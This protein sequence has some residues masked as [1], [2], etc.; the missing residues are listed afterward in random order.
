MNRLFNMITGLGLG[1]GLMYLFD[2]DR[3]NRRRGLMRDQMIHL[4]RKTGDTL[5]AAFND[6]GNR[7]QGVRAALESW[8]KRKDVPDEVLVQRIRSKMGRF[9]S[10]PGSVKVTAHQG[11]VTL[12]GPILVNEANKLLKTVSSM[13]N[14]TDVENRLEVHQQASDV[15]GLQGVSIRPEQ[16]QEG[17]PLAARLLIGLTGGILALYGLMRRGRVGTTLGTVGLGLLARGFPKVR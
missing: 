1:A 16:I 9:V 7:T 4:S 8:R 2:P 6:L 10:H 13:R 11:H 15:P 3:G 17:W 12:S 14:I 5:E